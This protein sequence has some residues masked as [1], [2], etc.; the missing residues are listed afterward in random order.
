M[1]LL[2]ALLRP[3]GPAHKVPLK[4]QR[5]P[6]RNYLE[7]LWHKLLRGR[8]HSS[9]PQILVLMDQM[10]LLRLR[11]D[12]VNLLGNLKGGS[13]LQWIQL[14]QLCGLLLRKV[15]CRRFKAVPCLRLLEIAQP[16][17]KAPL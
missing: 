3:K 10:A 5:Q 13:D 1:G 17:G 9:K 7:H 2:Q 8:L 12:A 4:V 6:A 15:L 11:L 16:H 14:L